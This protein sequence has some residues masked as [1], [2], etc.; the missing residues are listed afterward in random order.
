MSALQVAASGKTHVGNIRANNEDTIRFQTP[1]HDSPIDSLGYLYAIADGM[2]GYE[3]GSIASEQAIE[4]FFDTFYRGHPTKPAQNM[5]QGIQNANLAVY[6]MAQRLNARMGTTL[7]AL[8]LV[9]NRLNIA[10]VGD[11]RVYLIRG[12]KA[13]CL[14]N[15]HTVVGE[16]VRMKILSPEKVRTHQ[17]RSVLEKCLG[18]Q[19]FIQPDIIHQTLSEGDYLILCSDGVWAF[20]EDDEFAQITHSVKMPEGICET[21]VKTAIERKSDDN[22]SAVTIHV[23]TVTGEAAASSERHIWALPQL[24]RGKLTG[25]A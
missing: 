25:K 9:G 20:I 2:G 15:D 8:N 24:L 6:Q 10:H 17:R 13:T 23:Q 19:L 12:R 4:S 1:Y 16:L 5:R 21:L 18:I 3:H 14:T 7:S 22:V 11:S